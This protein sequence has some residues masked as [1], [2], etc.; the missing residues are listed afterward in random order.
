[1][2]AILAW[3]TLVGLMAVFVSPWAL[4]LLILT[5]CTNTPKTDDSE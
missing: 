4:V 1:M 2:V 5:S 3:F